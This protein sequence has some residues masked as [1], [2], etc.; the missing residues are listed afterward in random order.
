M[1]DSIIFKATL[2]LL[3]IVIGGHVRG[4]IDD[5]KQLHETLT[6]NNFNKGQY[7]V[8]DWSKGECHADSKVDK[9]CTW[10]ESTMFVSCYSNGTE[11][12]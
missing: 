3:G 5:T 12:R 1:R 7:V 2:I 4:C 11:R 9:V 8:N 6:F 10:N